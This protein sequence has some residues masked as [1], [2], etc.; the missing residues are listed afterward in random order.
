MG[1]LSM[2]GHQNSEDF[3]QLCPHTPA[4]G[5]EHPIWE[6]Q[7]DFNIL[8][9]VVPLPSYRVSHKHLSGGGS[10]TPH[11]GGHLVQEMGGATSN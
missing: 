4:G 6:S 8:V 1:S 5:P 2:T 10:T 11:W 9:D 7:L 3:W